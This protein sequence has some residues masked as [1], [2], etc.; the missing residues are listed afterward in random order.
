MLIENSLFVNENSAS[1]IIWNPDMNRAEAK[2]KMADYM[3]YVRAQVCA[4]SKKV[5]LPNTLEGALSDQ[6]GINFLKDGCKVSLRAVNEKGKLPFTVQEQSIFISGQTGMVIK[7]VSKEE[8]N[9]R[10]VDK[11]DGY[12]GLKFD[13]N[14][15]LITGIYFNV[16][17]DLLIE[18]PEHLNKLFSER[19]AVLMKSLLGRSSKSGDDMIQDEVTM[20]TIHNDVNFET[21]PLIIYSKTR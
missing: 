9:M 3:K 5:D 17:Q 19:F 13:Q 14:D 4:K 20:T 2:Q 6:N 18:Y 11:K 21:K 10:L 12:F 16:G 1:E 7:F 8:D 15:N